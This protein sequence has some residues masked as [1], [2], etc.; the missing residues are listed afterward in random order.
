MRG[1]SMPERRGFLK[2]Q[3]AMRLRPL[4]RRRL[5]TLRPP[6]VLM[7]DRNPCTFLRRRLWGWKVRFIDQP[8]RRSLGRK[9]GTGHS[10]CVFASKPA[11]FLGSAENRFGSRLCQGDPRS[12]R[13]VRPRRADSV[14]ISAIHTSADTVNNITFNVL[15][16]ISH[17][18]STKGGQTCLKETAS[19]EPIQVLVS[20]YVRKSVFGLQNLL[21]PRNGQE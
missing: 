4:A 10:E 5:S 1:L 15:G 14:Q 11:C 6:S 21:L 16:V 19:G 20:K 13:S 2:R 18:L 7:R 17:N 8:F 3:T 12:E 9:T